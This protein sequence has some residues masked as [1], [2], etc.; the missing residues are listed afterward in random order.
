MYMT[1]NASGDPLGGNFNSVALA[2][3]TCVYIP[4]LFP[5]NLSRSMASNAI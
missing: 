3:K 4:K 5:A 2:L 1:E